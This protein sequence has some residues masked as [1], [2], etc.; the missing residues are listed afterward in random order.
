MRQKHKRKSA[1]ANTRDPSI[2]ADDESENDTSIKDASSHVVGRTRRRSVDEATQRS[3]S[4]S[5]RA[6][7]LQSSILTYIEDILRF[8]QMTPVQAATIPLLI[9]STKKDVIV[10]AVTGSGKTLAFLLPIVQSLATFKATDGNSE[11]PVWKKSQIFSMIISPTRELAHQT[12]RVASG[13]CQAV[14]LSP[15]LLLT[16]GGTN[17]TNADCATSAS[18]TSSTVTMDLTRFQQEHNDIIIGTPGRIEDIL[19]RYM[20]LDCSELRYLIFD[21]ADQLLLDNRGFSL[22]VQSILSRLPKMGRRTGLFSAT[23]T[24]ATSEWIRRAG[25]RNPVWID[26]TVTAPS[27]QL[28][29]KKQNDQTTTVA[30]PSSL[31]NYYIISP[32]D[33]KLS[34]LVSFLQSHARSEKVIVFFLTCACVDFFGT[35][36]TK[37][38]CPE[39]KKSDAF[40]SSG[41]YI[42]ML[43]GKMVQKRR[44]NAMERFRKCG[45]AD[46]PTGGVLFCTDVAARGLDVSDVHWVVQYDPPQDPAY[47]IH[48]VGRSARAGKRGQSLVFLTRKEEAYVDFL[49]KRHVPLQPLPETESCTP[50]DEHAGVDENPSV[51]DADRV[52]TDAETSDD[53]S[54]GKKTTTTPLSADEGQIGRIVRHNVMGRVLTDILPQVR[55]LV[56][57]D[58]DILEKGTKAFTSYIRAYKEHHCAFIFRYVFSAMVSVHAHEKRGQRLVRKLRVELL[59]V[60]KHYTGRLWTANDSA[61]RSCCHR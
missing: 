18:A 42:E 22:S 32:L 37:L 16:G 6:L 11:A 14:E 41:I 24:T 26:V 5:F 12:F 61:I 31:T 7:T 4:Q 30:T 23:N 38:L 20:A 28:Q 9:S 50:P 51:E 8:E 29:P 59:F 34:R 3:N 54:D 27:L 44:E 2:K 58:R 39:K 19:T 60:V 43:H 40:C 55:E 10:Q 56:L 15:P 46:A 52:D 25:L 49:S 33:E 21:E 45:S 35:V 47:F 36:L 1:S 57:N 48:R 17:T 13:L 53:S